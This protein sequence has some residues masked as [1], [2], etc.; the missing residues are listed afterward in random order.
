[1]QGLLIMWSKT[2]SSETVVELQKLSK[3]L[4]QSYD[5]A[6]Q[7]SLLSLLTMWQGRFAFNC[8]A[9]TWQQTGV[10]VLWK[11][12]PRRRRI[13]KKKLQSTGYEWLL[14]CNKYSLLTARPQA[15]PLVSSLHSSWFPVSFKCENFPVADKRRRKA[16]QRPSASHQTSFLEG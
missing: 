5:K 15:P 2:L 16:A 1:M 9:V 6:S 14:G 8:V 13:E 7:A 10:I 11:A 4:Q 3:S 12:G